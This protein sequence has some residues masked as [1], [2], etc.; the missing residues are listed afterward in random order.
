MAD[1]V[2][3]KVGSFFK[4]FGVVM[5]ALVL[6]VIVVAIIAPAPKDEKKVEVA[7]AS[8]V[9]PPKLGKVEQKEEI[10]ASIRS[11]IMAMEP[12]HS[13]VQRAVEAMGEGNFSGSTLGQLQLAQN[14]CHESEAKL[15]A[16]ATPRIDEPFVGQ[17]NKVMSEICSS[18]TKAQAKSLDEFLVALEGEPQISDLASFGTQAG[19]SFK[20]IGLCMKSLD[21]IATDNGTPL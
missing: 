11:V 17:W 16:I 18:G 1:M 19:A 21:K 14:H 12:C 8:E 3:G 15:S 13:S 6:I 4:W 10:K 2:S 9:V 20:T 5:G 7:A